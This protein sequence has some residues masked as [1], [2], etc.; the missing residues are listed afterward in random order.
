MNRHGCSLTA[1]GAWMAAEISCR[2]VI[3]SISSS[4]YGRTERRLKI[5]S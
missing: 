2:I 1:F 4:A 3:P 5:A